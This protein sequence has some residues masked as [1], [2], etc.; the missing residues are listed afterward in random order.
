MTTLRLH[1][2]HLRAPIFLLTFCISLSCLCLE[3]RAQQPSSTPA[4][5]DAV[6]QTPA[7]ELPANGRVSNHTDQNG[8][9]GQ[10]QDG[11]VQVLP[12]TPNYW[13]AS[14]P[15]TSEQ[16]MKRSL[17]AAFLRPE[18]YIYATVTATIT[19]RRERA[20][21]QKTGGDR[22]ADGLSRFARDFATLSVDEALGSGVYPSIFK[23]DPRY[24]PSIKHGFFPRAFHA[25]SREF[26]T[27]S[28][29]GKTQ[30]NY[31]RLLGSLS[32]SAIANIYERD[33]PGHRRIGVSPTFQ[34]FGTF[35][36]FE[37]LSNIVFKEF[38]HDIK[39]IFKL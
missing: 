37:I 32:A 2:L 24:S 26:V 17:R 12:G 22:F 33:T 38:G 7:P 14:P 11:N 18:D 10:A 19:E 34:R 16:K 36:G 9:S 39:K 35:V 1:R 8:A 15:L 5:A 30:P 29:A 20:Q 27:Y 31:S 21:P 6:P 3:A 25:A 4:A 28:D 23:Q 13:Y